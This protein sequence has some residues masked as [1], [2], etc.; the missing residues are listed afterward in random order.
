MKQSIHDNIMT[1]LG[2]AEKNDVLSNK[3]AE[4]AYAWMKEKQQLQAFVSEP[5]PLCKTKQ[6]FIT[7]LSHFFIEK[8]FLI[9]REN[10]PL[11]KIMQFAIEHAFLEPEKFAWKAIVML[12]QE[13][14]YLSD[15][16][17]FHY[18]SGQ[19]TQTL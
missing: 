8:E 10:L 5:I 1:A 6:E 12:R 4:E 2:F 19:G 3:E 16:S 9:M 14:N 17:V 15:N 18:A 11:P 7:L 13:Y